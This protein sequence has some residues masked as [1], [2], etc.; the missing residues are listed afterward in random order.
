[1]LTA[2]ELACEPPEIHFHEI[3]N[4]QGLELV[5]ALRIVRS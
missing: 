3:T 2:M 4:S 1:V 5:E